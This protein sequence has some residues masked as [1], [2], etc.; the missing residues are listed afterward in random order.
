M[1]IFVVLRLND[2]STLCAELTASCNSLSSEWLGVLRALCWSSNHNC[3]FID[4][5]TH[6]DVSYVKITTLYL[7]SVWVSFLVDFLCYW[8]G[9]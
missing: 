9:I 1:V 8:Y 7:V 2:I 6:V 4:I 5:L 3:G